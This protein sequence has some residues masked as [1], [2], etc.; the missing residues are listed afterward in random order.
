MT[1]EDSN[2]LDDFQRAEIV[3]RDQADLLLRRGSTKVGTARTSC[4]TDFSG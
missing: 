2:G 1:K 3:L 4:S